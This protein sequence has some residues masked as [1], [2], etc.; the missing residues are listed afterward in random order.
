MTRICQ[1]VGL[2]L[3]KSIC[4]LLRTKAYKVYASQEVRHCYD[5]P[6]VTS[7]KESFLPTRNCSPLNELTIAKTTDDCQQS[8][9]DPLPLLPIANTRSLL[10]FGQEFAQRQN[11]PCFLGKKWVKVNFK[12]LP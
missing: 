2:H 3:F 4:I 11:I 8:P 12:K 9:L 7:R 5:A 1:F 6:Q 10:W